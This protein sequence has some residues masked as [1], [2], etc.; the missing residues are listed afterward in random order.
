M[1]KIS[2][3]LIGLLTLGTAVM[4]SQTSAAEFS[5]A[6]YVGKPEACPRGTHFSPRKDGQCWSCPAGMVRTLAPIT[7]K[8][9]CKRKKQTF[10]G[11][12]T[13]HA[14]NIKHKDGCPRGQFWRNKGGK[15][16][17]GAC[18]S[19]P[20]GYAPTLWSATGRKACKKTIGTAH[21]RARFVQEWG[22]P[23][24]AHFS[25]R[26]GGQCWSCPAGSFRTVN[27]VTGAKACSSNL[28]GILSPDTSGLC[29]LVL[30]AVKGGTD[31][32][33]KV[34]EKLDKITQPLTRP[35]QAAMQKFVP[36]IKSPRQLNE[37][38]NKL[39]TAF[40]PFGPVQDEL[41]RIGELGLRN[42][43][44]FSRIVLNPALMCG[45]DKRKIIRALRAAGLNPD[46]KARRA[47]LMDGLFI[48]SAHA[49]TT[50]RERERVFYGIFVSSGFKNLGAPFGYMLGVW[51][52]T[53][54]DEHL[55]VYFSFPGIYQ[56]RIPGADITTGV[57][58]F[59]R[60]T[61]DNFEKINQLGI[62]L[63][64]GRA[65]NA[66]NPFTFLEKLAKGWPDGLNVDFS[67]DPEFFVHP[68]RN[69]PGMGVSWGVGQDWSG[70]ADLG[71]SPKRMAK[72]AR[73]TTTKTTGVVVSVDYTAR[74]GG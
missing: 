38:G 44:R 13:R 58:I 56:S 55:G 27:K 25:P 10:Y 9:A 39:A 72:P 3:F 20:R 59:P 70:D 34:K 65:Q 68:R 29:K 26:R 49:K 53:D 5:K 62:G 61:S 54:M 8:K 7:S 69:P 15:G 14:T 33:Q 51:V 28:A 37:L 32:A 12:A 1:I 4:T 74:L 18:Y 30:G 60:S 48:R 19:C 52:I 11:R 22:C 45:G 24:G 17:K 67:F 50:G 73:P 23:K 35:V 2:A 47:S 31:G 66:K 64:F 16:F 71:K 36:S 6:T 43:G 21:A 41:K 42:P 63:S 57:M 40:R 46:F